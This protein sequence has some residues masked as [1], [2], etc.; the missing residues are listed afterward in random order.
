MNRSRVNVISILMILLFALTALAQD[1]G[2]QDSLAFGNSDGSPIQVFIDH[3]VSIPIYL[4]CDENVSF[5]HF[6]LA[7][8]N[9]YVPERGPFVPSGPL[10]DWILYGTLPVDGWP[11]EGLTS[12]SLVGIADFSIPE[13]NYINTDNEWLYVGEFRIQTT[14]NPDAMGETS[15]LHPGE[16]PIEGVTVI[17]DETWAPIVPAMVFSS[18][19]FLEA[20][21]PVIVSPSSDTLI[22]VSNYYPFAFTVIATDIDEDDISLSAECDY[23]GYFFEEINSYPGNAEYQFSWTPPENCDSVVQVIFTATDDDGLSSE[24]TININVNPVTVSVTS[25]STLPGYQASVDV[26]LIQNGSNSNVGGFDLTFMWDANAFE[27]EYVDFDGDF[28][29]WEYL[30]ASIDPYGPGSLI[31]VGL[32]N[33]GGGSVPPM[34]TGTYHI[35]RIYLQASDDQNLQG[36]IFPLAMPTDNMSYNAL[37]DSSGY[38]VY[39]PE[40]IPGR[41]IFMDLGDILI[42]DIN[43]NLIPY[44]MGDAISFIN[45]LVDPLQYPFNTTQRYASDCNQDFIPE[46]IADLIF[47]LNIINGGLATSE[48]VINELPELKLKL[49]RSQVILQLSDKIPVG[50]LLVKLN[51]PGVEIDNISTSPD[52]ELQYFNDENILTAVIYPR[53][54]NSPLS[55]NII[56]FE[57]VSGNPENIMVEKAEFSTPS[58]ALFR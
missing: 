19:E 34:R 37:S 26:Y 4:K 45:H 15:Q 32:A 58:G 31:L 41:I 33:L 47:M 56:S 12:Q 25:D 16:D 35:A 21:P 46:T 10:A 36:Y 55:G 42:G 57:A 7:T 14:D 50:G 28:D 27:V 6:C 11:Q 29:E 43:L 40:L 13:P 20:T 51:L 49:D 2:N 53:N 17:F 8:E 9:S 39:H 30:N 18:L 22:T 52:M 48:Q 1:P 23:D 54:V 5:V 44:E 38:L 24:T 3:E